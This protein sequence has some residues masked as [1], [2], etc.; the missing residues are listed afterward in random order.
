MEADRALWY[1]RQVDL[2]AEMSDEEMRDLSSVTTLREYARGRVVLGEGEHARRLYILKRGHV[3]LS[4]YSPEGREQILA[5]LDPGDVF[6]AES[7]V[8]LGETAHA[9]VFED[10]LICEVPSTVFEAIVQRRPQLALRVIRILAERLAAVEEEVRSL[11][12]REVPG[13]LAALLLRLAEEYCEA[14]PDGIR[15]TLRLTHHD[16]AGMIGATRETVTTILGRMKAEGAIAA[17]GRVL[18]VRDPQALRALAGEPPD[19]A[20]PN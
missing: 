14:R 2:F 3:K 1:L 12:F 8:G 6:G 18:I 4:A 5:L 20:S 10:A 9:E 15:L 19:A 16:I 17:E 7:L 11:A 13:R